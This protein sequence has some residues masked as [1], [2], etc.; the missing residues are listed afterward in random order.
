MSNKHLID[1]DK[2]ER[3][4]KADLEDFI[5]V[6]EV[7]RGSW[8]D[9]IYIDNGSNVLGVAHLDSVDNDNR[10]K[11]FALIEEGN[12]IRVFTRRLDDRLGVYVLL[13]V[14]PKMGINVD[15]LLTDGEE[16]CRSSA[17]D[18]I[19]EKEYNW[20]FQFDR[21]G[22]DVVTYDYIDPEWEAEIKSTGFKLGWG[23]YS[24]IC[25]LYRLGVCGMNIGTGYHFEHTDRCHAR[26]KDTIDMCVLFKKFY[27]KNKDTKWVHTFRPHR[28][29]YAKVNWGPA[30]DDVGWGQTRTETDK[31]WYYHELY[32]TDEMGGYETWRDKLYDEIAD[33]LCDYYGLAVPEAEQIA[34]DACILDEWEQYNWITNRCG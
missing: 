18:F 25:E 8:N 10:G 16:T 27:D 28:Y 23:S 6:G 24:D 12:D 26:L 19:A 20:I 15:V 22:T 21:R 2:L 31:N 7:Y 13:H 3:I 11:D 5:E 4:C 29:A 33:E 32:K 14:L 17:Q 30:Y 1:L 34:Y 9:Y